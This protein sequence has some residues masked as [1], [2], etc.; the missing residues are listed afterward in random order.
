MTEV[1]SSAN[2]GLSQPLL[3]KRTSKRWLISAVLTTAIVALPVLSVI[4]LALFPDENIWPHLIETTLPRYLTTTIKLMIGVGAL[5]LLIGLATAWAV[6]MCEFP[7]RKFFEWALLLPFAVPAY[8]IAY[9]YT[10]LLDYAGPVQRGLREWFGWQ[11]ASDY[12]FPEIRSLEGAILMIGLV[13]YPYV[14]LLGRAAFLEQSPSL[15]AVSRS[16]GHSALSTFFRVVLPIAR[17]AIAVGLSLVLMETLNDF[18]T[19]DFFAVQTLTRGLFDTWMNLGNLGGAAQIATTMLIFVV[20][21]VTLERY[22][23]RRQ[24][25]YAARDNRDPIHRFTMSFPRQMICVVVCAVPLIFGFII[26]GATLGYYAWEYFDVSWNPDFIQNTFNS[27]FLSSAAALTTLI[28]GVTLAYSRRLHN[29]RGM[30]ILMRLSSLGYA[31]PGA[32]L[33]VGVIVPLAGFDN[34]LDSLMRD[35]LGVSTGLLLSGTAFALIFAYTVRFLAVSA[36]SVESALQKITPSMDMASRSLGHTPGKTLIN[37]HLPMLRGTLVTAA[38]VVF[39]DCMKELPATLI[40]RPFNYETLATYVYQFASD[41][42]LYHSALPALIIVVA[43]I[44]PII[45]MNRSISNSRTM[46]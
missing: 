6:T 5:T 45:L 18:G 31:M 10:S 13:L 15:F 24:Q 8:V 7:G 26:P 2:P 37:V 27:L 35:Y 32:V 39:V 25:Q 42:Q 16:L 40:L 3:A 46:A 17:P 38:L 9:V 29:T 41:E 43:G 23:R 20:I 14:Y 34:W 1:V 36:G 12:W 19:V 4:F 28:I 44:I 30:Q 22:S 33:A 11:N 21:L